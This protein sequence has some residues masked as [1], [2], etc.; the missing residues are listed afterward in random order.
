MSKFIEAFNILFGEKTLVIGN[1]SFEKKDDSYY[2]CDGE[3]RWLVNPS[4]LGLIYINEYRRESSENQLVINFVGGG[5]FNLRITL[6]DNCS[7]NERK[8]DFLLKL[9][10]KYS[11]NNVFPKVVTFCLFTAL[12]IILVT[13]ISLSVFN[14]ATGLVVDKSVNDTINNQ[15]NS[16][17]E[18]TRKTQLSPESSE[19]VSLSPEQQLL[20]RNNQLIK[21][22][23]ELVTLLQKGIKAG[24][25][26]FSLGPV[27]PENKGTLYVFS[28][29]LC[30]RCQDI[31]PLLEE[32]SSDYQIQIF[33][34]SLIGTPTTIDASSRL[35]KTVLC[36]APESRGVVWQKIMRDPNTQTA[37]CESGP[38][39][40]KNNIDTYHAYNF[41][42]TPALIRGDGASFDLTKRKSAESVTRWLNEAVQ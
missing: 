4:S 36:E 8:M 40:L 25:Y 9:K 18:T 42:G 28:D 2:I 30:P 12:N 39:A 24:D 38:I 5:D 13:F 15:N 27:K 11:K 37:D 41:I 32:L 6:K 14:S 1:T 23:S 22:N 7:S 10:E 16:F 19:S 21:P 29:P 35:V 26:S 3:H 34:V 17:S 31:E 20:A 33:P